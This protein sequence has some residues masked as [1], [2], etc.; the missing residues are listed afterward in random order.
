VLPEHQEFKKIPRLSREIVITEKIDGTNGVVAIFHKAELPPEDLDNPAVLLVPFGGMDFVMLAGS[1]SRWISPVDDN[2]GFARWVAQ[3]RDE[4][5]TLGPGTHYGE[6]W[7]SGIQRGY[8]LTKGEKRWSLFNTTRWALKRPS[9]CSCVPELYRGA[10]STPH[11]ETVLQ[12]LK[13]LGSSAA[14]GF[15]NPEGVIVYHVAG[16]LL[17][18]KT[19]HKDEEPKGKTS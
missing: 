12:Q 10:F 1:K 18:K 15:M 6:W 13:E 8:G 17:F 2:F 3:H 7:G 5:V 4:L 11:I 14:L 19:L 9:C 16:D